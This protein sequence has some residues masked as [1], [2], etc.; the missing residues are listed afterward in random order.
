MPLL[1][2]MQL[3]LQGGSPGTLPEDRDEDRAPHASL[4]AA[5]T[6]S[7]RSWDPHSEPGVGRMRLPD[8]T[9][10]PQLFPIS[11]TKLDGGG[12]DQADGQMCG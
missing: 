12:A 10:V 3:Q 9:A 6:G 7:G 5:A 1:K 8:P 11:G 4:A 2:E